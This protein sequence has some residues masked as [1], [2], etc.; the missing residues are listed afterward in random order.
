M[1]ITVDRAVEVLGDAEL[2]VITVDEEFKESCR[3]GKVA[4]LALKRINEM[5]FRW[6]KEEEG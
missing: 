4:L 2:G 6:Q 3:Q 1:P 5:D